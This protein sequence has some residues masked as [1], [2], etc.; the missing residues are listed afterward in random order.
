MCLGIDLGTTFVKTSG[1]RC[2]QSGISTIIY[3]NSD[4]LEID[5]QKYSVGLP[6]LS[7]IN[8]NKSLNRNSRL[9]FLYA[10]FLESQQ[11]E[12]YYDEVVCGL[13]CSQWKNENT[14]E[15][16][17]NTLLPTKSLEIKLNNTIKKITIDNLTI[18]PEGAAAYYAN[19]MNNFRFH[20]EKVL[21]G[22]LGSRT[23][24]QLLF[25]NDELIDTFTEELGV[26]SLYPRMAECI[27]TG[28]GISIKSNEI[29]GILKN[30]LYHKGTQIDIEPFISSITIEYAETIYKNLQLLW[31]VDNI[32]YVIFIGGGSII[33]TKYLKQFIPQIELISNAQTISAIG[34]GEGVA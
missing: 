5:N 9:N 2:F 15:Q 26:L 12:N 33:M 14:I 32:K 11:E 27:S 28:T 24:N 16:F 31:N 1:E 6:N 30:G 23:F 25:E 17:K 29:Y 20:G 19:D 10:L 34:M 13:P 4:I 22:D 3:P 7:D 8:I 21:I 18:I